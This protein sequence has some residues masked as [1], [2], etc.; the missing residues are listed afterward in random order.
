MKSSNLV[1]S[2]KGRY[3]GD[4]KQQRQICHKD[5]ARRRETNHQTGRKT[6]DEEQGTDA[7]MLILWK[8]MNLH[9]QIIK[10]ETQ[11]VEI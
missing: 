8:I 2:E 1:L 4:P 11:D 5:E 3:T 9:T 10:Q 7:R 6:R